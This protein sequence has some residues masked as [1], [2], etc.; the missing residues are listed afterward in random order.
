MRYP[1]NKVADYTVVRPAGDID[2]A[3]APALRRQLLAHLR[4]KHHLLVDLSAVT[5]LD[6]SGT[7]VFIEAFHAAEQSGLRF[8]LVAVST[9]ALTVL[10]LSRLDQVLPVHASIEARLAADQT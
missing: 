9:A 4:S 1:E 7:A 2:L 5:Y 3:H 6:S 10:K 8:G